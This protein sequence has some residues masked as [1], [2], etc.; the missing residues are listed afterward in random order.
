[1]REVNWSTKI[2]AKQKTVSTHY[3]KLLSDLETLA[4]L[5]ERDDRPGMAKKYRTD[6]EAIRKVYVTHF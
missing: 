2:E 3:N 5:C 6:M 4:K 1:V